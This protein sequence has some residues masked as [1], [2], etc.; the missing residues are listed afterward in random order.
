M[1]RQFSSVYYHWLL[2]L[3]NIQ[4]CST[5]L[6]LCLATLSSPCCWRTTLFSLRFHWFLPIIFLGP[7]PSSLSIRHP[8]THYDTFLYGLV[9]LFY[10]FC[11]SAIPSCCSPC[12][13]TSSLPLLVIQI[14]MPFLSLSSPLFSSLFLICIQSMCS[15]SPRMQYLRRRR[16]KRIN[17]CWWFVVFV[18]II[19]ILLW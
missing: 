4:I 11:R 9:L 3:F 16:W 17:V 19:F 7:M 10:P 12:S 5:T 13:H 18:W 14:S 15:T 2:L 8:N 6:Q 1:R